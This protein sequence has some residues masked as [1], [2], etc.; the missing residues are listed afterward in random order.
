MAYDPLS[1]ARNPVRVGADDPCR[2]FS[3]EYLRPRLKSEVEHTAWLMEQAKVRH[4]EAKWVY[5]TFES[6]VAFLKAAKSRE[7]G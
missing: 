3:E 5:D 6:R 7:V 1:L 4:N 2:D